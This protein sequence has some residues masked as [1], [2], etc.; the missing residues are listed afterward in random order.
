VSIFDAFLPKPWDLTVFETIQ[1]EVTPTGRQAFGTY[2]EASATGI[3]WMATKGVTTASFEGTAG[4]DSGT[5]MSS[6]CFDY[7]HER[8]DIFCF[9]EALLLHGKSTRQKRH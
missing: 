2:E 1:G 5:M 3:A 8:D 7:T 4:D 9:L 6:S